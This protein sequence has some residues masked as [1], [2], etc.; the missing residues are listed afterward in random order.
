MREV[1]KKDRRRFR[2]V[3][4]SGSYRV[5]DTKKRVFVAATRSFSEAAEAA[6]FAAQS[7]RNEE[8]WSRLD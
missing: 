4:L 2:V 1:Q 6:Y 7:V 3:K 8:R 5:L